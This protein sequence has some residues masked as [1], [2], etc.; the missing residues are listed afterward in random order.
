MSAIKPIETHYAGCRFRSRLEARWAVFFDQLEIHWE[1]EAQGYALPSGA[2]Y[3]PDFW[4]PKLGLHVEVKGD[5]ASFNEEGPRYAEAIQS[6]ALPGYGL[7]ILGPVPN[8][9][10]GLPKHLVLVGEE[11]CCGR[12][13]ICLHVAMFDMLTG[14]SPHSVDELLAC[15]DRQAHDRVPVLGPIRRD[16]QGVVAGGRMPD[17]WP[18]APC[19]SNAYR[20]A[21]SARFEHGEQW[22]A[23]GANR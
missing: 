5:E 1:Y 12:P 23:D 9:E 16:W 10:E 8:A 7:I 21:R 14:E 18:V 20:A 19:L 22:R 3:L 6:G 13:I 4:L 17:D 2:S 11:H 15:T